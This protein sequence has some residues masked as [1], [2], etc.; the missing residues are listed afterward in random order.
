MELSRARSPRPES[1]CVDGEAGEEGYFLMLIYH[2]ANPSLRS[3][4]GGEWTHPSVGIARLMST[5]KTMEWSI[6]YMIYY[7]HP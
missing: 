2:E 4:E 3:A 7:T 5:L 1:V 6:I